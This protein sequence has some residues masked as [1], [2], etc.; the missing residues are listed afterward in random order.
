MGGAIG[1]WSRDAV[2]ATTPLPAADVDGMAARLASMSRWLVK[3][4][5]GLAIASGWTVT[6]A[7]AIAA[8]TT[9]WSLLPQPVDMRLAPSGVVRIADGALVGAR[10]AD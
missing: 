4:L 7:F 1:H 5:Y 8:P 10:G 3:L 6:T 9:T 2:V